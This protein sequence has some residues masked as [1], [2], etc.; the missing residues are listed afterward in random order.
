MPTYQ[1][2]IILSINWRT[3]A[4]IL[5]VFYKKM[6][7][8]IRVLSQ[9]G[10]SKSNAIRITAIISSMLWQPLYPFFSYCSTLY[11][12]E[13]MSRCCN[14]LLSI[15][16]STV[17]HPKHNKWFKNSRTNRQCFLPLRHYCMMLLLM[18]LA[19]D[20]PSFDYLTK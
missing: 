11:R 7:P 5:L 4:T 20:A 1:L 6:L 17:K 9:E 14:N 3:P 13:V 2:Y 16:I 12:L 10:V 19:F 18:V 8:K 15:Y